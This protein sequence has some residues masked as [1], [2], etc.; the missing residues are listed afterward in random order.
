VCHGNAKATTHA[1]SILDPGVDQLLL[2]FLAVV[3]HGDGLVG[4]TAESESECECEL[5]TAAAGLRE[6]E[7]GRQGRDASWNW[8]WNFS[9]SV[10]GVPLSALSHGKAE[11]ETDM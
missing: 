9:V 7:N 4:L 10:D 2:R 6:R 8:N 5:R 11:A 3:R 1:E